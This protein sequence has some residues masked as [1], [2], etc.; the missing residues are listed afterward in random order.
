MS[1][2]PR[3]AR[4]LLAYVPLQLALI[5]WGA[6]AVGSLDPWQAL[7]LTLSIGLVT[8]AQGITIA[9]ELGHKRSLLP[10][11]WFAVMNPRVPRAAV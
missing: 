6:S 3:D 5:A 11:P 10:P 9:H 2:A 8:G 7:G 4:F 1:F